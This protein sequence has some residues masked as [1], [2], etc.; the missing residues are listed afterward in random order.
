[1]LKDA[2]AA[3]I[4]EENW[5]HFDGDRYRLLAWV[6]M[7]NHVHLL[8]E[9]WQVPQSDLVRDWKGYTAHRINRL[10]G[11]NGTLWQADYWDRYI[12]DEE[13]FRKA[14]RYIEANPVKAALVHAPAEWEW[15]SARFRDEYGRLL[16]QK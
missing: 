8:V 7:P 12:R 11:T 10:L 3:R 16:G 1:M 15:S 2:Q 6:V 5:L 4:I 9:I 14:I 13:H